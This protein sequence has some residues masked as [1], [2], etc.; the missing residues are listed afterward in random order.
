MKPRYAPVVPYRLSP[1]G[2]LGFAREREPEAIFPVQR[3]FAQVI[4]RLAQ[5]LD[6]FVRRAHASVIGDLRPPHNTKIFAPSSAPMSI[7][8]I[9]FCTANARSAGLSP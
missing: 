1:R 6:R 2:S 7:A 8:L 5:P 4:D 9:A 3:V